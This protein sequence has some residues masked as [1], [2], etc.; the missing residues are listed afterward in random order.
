M[1]DTVSARRHKKE[2]SKLSKTELI[3]VMLEQERE[4]ETL[5]SQVAELKEIIAEREIV[6]DDSE[7]LAHAALRLS[8]I[9]EAADRAC[10]IYRDSLRR[11]E[12]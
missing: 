5:R 2:L 7:S 6:I 3:A 11:I 12:K 4:N 10:E 8:G 9:F 1:A